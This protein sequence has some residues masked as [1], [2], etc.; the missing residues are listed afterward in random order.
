MANV[1]WSEVKAKLERCNQAHLLEHLAALPEAKQEA[2][3]QQLDQLD[4]LRF[5]EALQQ[6]QA[7]LRGSASKLAPIPYIDWE[8]LDE[9]EKKRNLEAGWSLLRA[10]KVGVLTAAGGQGS[11]LGHTGPKGTFDIGLPSRKSLFELQAD[12]LCRL[13]RRAGASL[14]WYIMT[15]PDNH[16]ET[17]CFF[18]SK[19]YFG[20]P[21]EDCFFFQQ[22]TMPAAGLEG[23]LLLSSSSEV[24][25][26]PSGNGEC[27]AS[28][29]S[30][31]A[32][33]DMKV[34]GV[35]WVF[36]YNVDN[37]L[38][39]IA[40]PA[41]VGIA[42]RSAH[43]VATKVI[44][45]RNPEEKIGISCLNDDRPAVLEY[46]EIP[47][48]LK[49]ST[50]PGLQLGNISIHLFRYDFIEEHS[51]AELPYHIALKKVPY[52]D[53]EGR[54]IQPQAPNALKLERFIFDFFPYAEEMTVLMAER[55]REFAPVK[56]KTG[57]DSPYTARS[58]VLRQYPEEARPAPPA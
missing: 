51:T 17:V 30:S 52:S 45:K 35:E 55:D 42:A 28:L 20:Y 48:Q 5:T 11:R 31:G 53:A 32:L 36:Y 7:N 15:S 34:R 26:A 2:L 49:A 43:P 54:I 41:F 9:Y 13:S 14:P 27:F 44:P 29:R 25:L 46:S 50:D 56:N 57:E 58:L 40:D 6:A 16:E 21:K 8:Q 19:H 12:R 18:E 38:I 22:H 1:L 37:A 39:Q 4:L 23:R 3:L 33:E 10:G 47:P 24:C